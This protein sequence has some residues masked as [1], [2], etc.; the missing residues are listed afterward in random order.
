[1]YVCSEVKFNLQED[2]SKSSFYQ[3][4]EEKLTYSY[5][6]HTDLSFVWTFRF[7]DQ[8]AKPYHYD[9]KPSRVYVEL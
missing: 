4:H 8:V 6:K 2:A 1:M 5:S 3:N 9:T 7:V